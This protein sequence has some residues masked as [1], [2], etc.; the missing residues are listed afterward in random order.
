MSLTDDLAEVVDRVAVWRLLP[1]R[2]RVLLGVAGMLWSLLFITAWFA[3]L[4]IRAGYQAALQGDAI[5]DATTAGTVGLLLNGLLG[6]A[7]MW[8]TPAKPCRCCGLL[9]KNHPAAVVR[10]SATA[11]GIEG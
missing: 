11:G 9:P 5:P 7:L 4:G 3:L 6:L 1:Y 2:V 10:G 8:Q